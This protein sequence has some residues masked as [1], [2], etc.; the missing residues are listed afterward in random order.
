M[1]WRL[2]ILTLTLATV[3]SEHYVIADDDVY[4]VELQRIKRLASETRLR[5]RASPSPQSGSGVIVGSAPGNALQ[6]YNACPNRD[7]L[8][9]AAFLYTSGSP[10]TL[11]CNY[12]TSQGSYTCNY[13][14]QT[15][16]L[17]PSLALC[18]ATSAKSV[19]SLRRL[20]PLTYLVRYDEFALCYTECDNGAVTT[21]LGINV[22]AGQSTLICRTQTSDGPTDCRFDAITSDFVSSSLATP[23]AIIAC[24]AQIILV[25]QCPRVQGMSNDFYNAGQYT[26][27]ASLDYGVINFATCG[28]RGGDIQEYQ[29]SAVAGG[30]P[31]LTCTLSPGGRGALA[32]L[33]ASVDCVYDAVTGAKIV[34]PTRLCPTLK[35][36]ERVCLPQ[37]KG[38][39]QISD[40]TYSL[41]N[42]QQFSTSDGDTSAICTINNGTG[43]ILC[44]FDSNGNLAADAP[45][46]CTDSQARVDV[47][48]C[49]GPVVSGYR[50]C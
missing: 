50:F 12:K 4:D 23:A 29:L 36:L 19:M 45:F 6:A 37:C 27:T 3:L 11:A 16:R 22:P 26:P 5:P 1:S 21:Y 18:Q 17:Q 39:C 20:Q 47:G 40:R 9:G 46:G 41:V 35:K 34:S 44:N 10:S 38:T 14:T 2:Y 25:G 49:A 32:D 8:T 43:T 24:Q 28:Y 33:D 7:S 13:D 42:G 15:G 30:N 48:Q 31:R